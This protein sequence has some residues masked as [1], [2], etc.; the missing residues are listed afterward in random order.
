MHVKQ[1]FGILLS[2]RRC[3]FLSF[4]QEAKTREGAGDCYDVAFVFP[5]VT[6]AHLHFAHLSVWSWL[7]LYRA[8][9]ICYKLF[10]FS[11]S[12][13]ANVSGF[14]LIAVKHIRTIPVG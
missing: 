2:A 11:F 8:F 12:L 7:V 10:S 13:V 3:G 4:H 14:P 9:W 1:A 5:T 6:L